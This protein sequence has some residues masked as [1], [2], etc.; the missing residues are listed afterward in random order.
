MSDSQAAPVGQPRVLLVN[1]TVFNDNVEHFRVITEVLGYAVD[2]VGHSNNGYARTKGP[3]DVIVQLGLGETVARR[4][5][6]SLEEGLNCLGRLRAQF[7][8]TPILVISRQ[9]ESQVLARVLA[10]GAD[11]YLYRAGQDEPTQF[12]YRLNQLIGTTHKPK[13]PR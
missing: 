9:E 2:A 12:V 4:K 7:P 8:T 1:V 3:F 5:E 10:R 13:P 11:D 6:D